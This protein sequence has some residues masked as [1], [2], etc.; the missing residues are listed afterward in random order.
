MPDIAIFQETWGPGNSVL[1][2]HRNYRKIPT[3]GERGCAL[4]LERDCKTL[5][6]FNTHL[7]AFSNEFK[8]LQLAEFMEFINNVL[9]SDQVKPKE[10]GVLICGDF[11]LRAHIKGD[12]Y[13]MLFSAF[14]S[15]GGLAVDLGSS[16][17]K[18]YDPIN[19]LV[20]FPENEGRIDYL[21]AI[22]AWKEIKI[23]LQIEKV[24]ID[25]L[26]EPILSD[27]FLQYI[28]IEMLNKSQI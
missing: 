12:E 21:I 22:N 15:Y 1:N 17:T 2:S 24:S 27:H 18:T 3:L 16:L 14:N 8:R 23:P 13:E 19:P 5:V 25:V 26:Q 20:T 11:N 7:D 10:F 9:R 4:I 28:T 6:V